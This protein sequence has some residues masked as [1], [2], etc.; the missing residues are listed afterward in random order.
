M[1]EEIKH[2]EWSCS[3][4]QYWIEQ[5]FDWV[6]I[7]IQIWHRMGKDLLWWIC[8]KSWEQKT[9]WV[10]LITSIG[11]LKQSIY[12][13]LVSQYLISGNKDLPFALKLTISARCAYQQGLCWIQIEILIYQLWEEWSPRNPSGVISTIG[14]KI[15][16]FLV[17][18]DL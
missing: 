17:L 2:K 8:D 9:Q 7:Q 15:T 12:K 6:T 4:A 3:H 11:T 1:F 5:Y 16:Q 18:W 14:C 13:H 10:Q